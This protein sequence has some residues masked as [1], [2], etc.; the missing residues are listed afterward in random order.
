MWFSSRADKTNDTY[1][2]RYAESDDGIKWIRKDEE[3]G[4]NVSDKGWDS[5][6]I[7]Y[8]FVFKH[9]NSHYMLYNGN[10]YGKSGIGLA[11]LEE[12]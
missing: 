1:R 2:I 4:I 8:P 3:V 5:E 9:N 12:E 7:C 10:S 6:M 11:V